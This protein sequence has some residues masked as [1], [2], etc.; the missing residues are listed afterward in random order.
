MTYALIE[1][2]GVEPVTL[3]EAKAHMRIDGVEEDALVG[4]LISI[5]TRHLERMA[6]IALITQRYRLYLDCWPI[7]GIVRIDHG[8][9]MR[10][11]AVTVYDAA[12]AASPAALSGHYL[13]G[14]SRPARLWLSERPAP[15]RALNGIEIDFTAGFGETGAEVP[16]ELKRAILM[17]VAL[18]FAYRGVVPPGDQ[19]A[20]IPD[21]YE[22]LIA[23]YGRRAL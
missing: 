23:P 6:G 22:R 11:D 10:V 4:A 9:V 16:D 13:D 17:H 2:P 8:P 18:M 14:A 20:A 19:P 3:A 12:G 7:S 5:A 21:G 1:G 15:G